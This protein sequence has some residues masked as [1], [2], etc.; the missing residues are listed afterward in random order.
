MPG[1]GAAGARRRARPRR[2][3]ARVR[4][5]AVVDRAR[6]ASAR[7][8]VGLD[9]SRA[10]LRH[11]RAAH[12]RRC[13]S[14]ARRA[15]SS[16]RSP[17]RAFDVVFCDHGALSFCDP[18]AHRCP[19]SPACCAPADCSRS[20][21]ATPLLYLTWNTEKEHADAPA[22]PHL[23]RPRP[24]RL[25]RRHRSTGCSRPATGSAC[26]ARNG[27]DVED[28]IELRPAAD[29]PT[30]YDEF[31]PAEVGAPLAGGV[32]LEGAPALTA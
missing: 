2:A 8:S 30:T 4:R 16:C 28:L 23:R 32:D 5:G 11:A 6:G 18:D 17:T 15:A 10:Q 12:R 22:A 13:R 3:R 31:A 21:H 9:V 14:L 26:C 27:F 7:A 1:V 29:A 19:R 20:A 24:H 25:R